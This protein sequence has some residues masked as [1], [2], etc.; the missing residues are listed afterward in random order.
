MLWR[1]LFSPLVAVVSLCVNVWMWVTVWSPD[2]MDTWRLKQT[3]SAQIKALNNPPNCQSLKQSEQ[4]LKL[5]PQNNNWICFRELNTNSGKWNTNLSSF[6]VKGKDEWQHIFRW[7]LDLTWQCGV[8]HLVAF[9]L[10]FRLLPRHLQL[11]GAQDL[12]TKSPRRWNWTEKQQNKQLYT[13]TVSVKPTVNIWWMI[14]KWSLSCRIQTSNM[15]IWLWG[16]HQC[17]LVD[18]IHNNGWSSC[19][20]SQEFISRKTASVWIKLKIC[21]CEH[22]K[23]SE[24]GVNRPF[25]S[26][27]IVY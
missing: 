10:S 1:W 19:L 5:R 9:K 25:K 20:F 27:K 7:V 26:C 13:I 16:N 8:N 2:T 15:F 14:I 11:G 12:C 23:G 22:I 3:V 17:V 6:Y 24:F 4:N 18:Y 21:C